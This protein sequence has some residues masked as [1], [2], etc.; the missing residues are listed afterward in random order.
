M[1]K[2][3]PCFSLFLAVAMPFT[4]VW[5]EGA[6]AQDKGE[7]SKS[8]KDKIVSL[9]TRED[10]GQKGV[11]VEVIYMTPEYLKVT[12]SPAGIE[13]YE[14]DKNLAFKVTLD[15]HSG[16]ITKYNMAKITHLRDGGGM[17]HQ[18]LRWEDVEKS[19]HHRSG[20]V[21]FSN[22]DVDGK[23]IVGDGVKSIE[24][25]VKDIAG[26]KERVFKW[27]LPISYPEN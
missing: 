23:P 5:S 8:A 12:N 21:L 27:E 2:L 14:L 9:L 15:T 6:V 18:A 26:V 13:K 22:L 16:D 7:S 3:L 11:S 24:V 10:G 25:V 17:E 1:K 20:I 4:L 19:S